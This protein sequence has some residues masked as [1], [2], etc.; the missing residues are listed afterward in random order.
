ML[1]DP[2]PVNVNDVSSLYCDVNCAKLYW[3][4][5]KVVMTLE[6]YDDSELAFQAYETKLKQYQEDEKYD[7]EC[8]GLDPPLNEQLIGIFHEE[9][10]KVLFKL[11][12]VQGPVVLTLV[13]PFRVECCSLDAAFYCGALEYLSNLQLQK[14]EDAALVTP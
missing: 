6:Q 7:G 1:D 9:P 3:G 11:V 14:I 5:E 4:Y 13:Y 10:G 2:E 8:Y 12:S